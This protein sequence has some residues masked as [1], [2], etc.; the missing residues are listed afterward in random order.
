MKCLNAIQ[1]RNEI[2]CSNQGYDVVE[3]I[4]FSRILPMPCSYVPSISFFS[5][6]AIK[7]NEQ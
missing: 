3:T 7:S 4:G 2:G 6:G 5:G 1:G